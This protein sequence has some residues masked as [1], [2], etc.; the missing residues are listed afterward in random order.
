MEKDRHFAGIANQIESADGQALQHFMSQS[1]WEEEG[2]YEQIQSEITA[3]P[4]LQKNGLLILDEYA[5]EKS[6]GKSAGTARQYNGRMGKVD[7]CQ[8]AVALGYA[9]W[10]VQPWPVWTLVDAE[11]F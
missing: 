8:V 4:E 9:N 6:G 3:I 10:K 2:V 5:D 1:P 11:S 7:E